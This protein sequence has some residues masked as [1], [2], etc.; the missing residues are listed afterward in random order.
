MKKSTR[1]WLRKA[2]ADYRA[3]QKLERGNDPL[4]DQSCFFFQQAAEKFLKALLEELG[5]S[6]P[7]IHRLQD[8]L[9]LLLPHHSSLRGLRRGL[10]FL[11]RFAVGTRYPGDNATKRDAASTMSTFSRRKR[12]FPG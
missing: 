2:E 7:R 4:H 11:T 3:A 10:V 8:L 9:P 1:E 12:A 5:L 6:I